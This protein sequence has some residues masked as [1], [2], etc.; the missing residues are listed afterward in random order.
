MS[1]ARR[2]GRYAE[3]FVPFF[4]AAT[5]FGAAS[6]PLW[7]LVWSGLLPLPGA[8]PLA[9]H[10]HEML[11]GYGLA[12]VGGFLFNKIDRPR[13]W[14]A[15][16]AWGAGRL[17]VLLGAVGTWAGAAVALA[18]PLC[19]LAF[20][21]LPFA[22]AAR[23][24]HNRV[25]APVL[26]A[27]TLAELLFQLGALGLLPEGERR[28]VMLAF[29]LLALLLVV[30]GGRIIPAATAGLIRE[31]GGFLAQRVQPTLEWGGVGS[32]ALAMLLDTALVL[33]AV[34]GI[35]SALGGAS[36]LARLARWMPHRTLDTPGILA[37]HLGYA[38]IG[39][40]LV[41]KGLAQTTGLATVADALHGVTVGG[42]GT[43]TVTMMLRTVLQRRGLTVR[44]GPLAAA[45]ALLP[46]AAALARLANSTLLA[47][48]LWAA[49]MLAATAA[50]LLALRRSRA[51]A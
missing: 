30:M 12:V 14:L 8:T 43:L 26:G 13:L 21:A 49:A 17:A 10:A 2:S 37:L 16:A 27:F 46:S 5:V 20:A 4:L 23:T 11:L 33:P 28:G 32:L 40:G 45:A 36:A 31:K 47:S 24:G 19:V 44:F 22:R 1:R 35:A 7:A 48:G 50:V 42:L 15:L 3:A 18:F 51:I 34:A 38:W 39:A 9:L 6:V 25:F 41:L 29:G